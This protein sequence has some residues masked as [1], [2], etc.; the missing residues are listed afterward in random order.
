MK[1]MMLRDGKILIWLLGG[2]CGGDRVDILEGETR[3]E[4]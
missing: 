3:S 2:D 1:G 4:G